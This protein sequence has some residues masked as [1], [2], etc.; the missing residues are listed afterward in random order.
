MHVKIVLMALLIAAA[1]Y[2]V[3]IV[4]GLEGSQAHLPR[5]EQE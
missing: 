4:P 1:V 2:F 3:V 5:T